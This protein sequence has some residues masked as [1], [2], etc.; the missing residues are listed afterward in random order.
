[1]KRIIAF[2]LLVSACANCLAAKQ[3]SR[4]MAEIWDAVRT[5]LERQSDAWFDDGDYPRA[6]NSLRV[7]NTLWPNEY[8][9]ATDLGWLLFSTEELDEELAVYVR[10]RKDNS[11]DPDASWP[12]ANFYFRKK[13]YGKVPPLLEPSVSMKKH[14]HPNS[15]RILAHSYERLGLLKDSK[16][17]WE[18]LLMLVP[19]DE[20]AKNNLRRVENKLR[21]AGG[22]SGKSPGARR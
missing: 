11:K 19:S 3:D 21:T 16:R 7:M 2:A 10:F 5:R 17:I 4:R 9:V 20:P 13:L 22:G 14:P 8:E 18:A 15:Y 6:V 1:M 12:E